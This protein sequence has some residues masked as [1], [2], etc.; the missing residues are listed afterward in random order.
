MEPSFTS[1]TY[2]P[3]IID[4]SF[5]SP[6]S[7]F[8]CNG[9]ERIM[10]GLWLRF[11]LAVERNGKINGSFFWGSVLVFSLFLWPLIFII[12]FHF[13]RKRNPRKIKIGQD[14]ETKNHVRTPD[15]PFFHFFQVTVMKS[16]PSL[17]RK[18][19]ELFYLLRN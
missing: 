12:P 2:R 9:K 4:L 6:R 15:E 3:T 17:M 19:T 5:P 8:G 14:K 18:R 1:A 16:F 11:L 13:E 7:L 10:V